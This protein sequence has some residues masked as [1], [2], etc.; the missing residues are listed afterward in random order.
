MGR[1]IVLLLLAACAAPAPVVVRTAPA[2]WPESRSREFVRLCLERGMGTEAQC[3]CMARELSD[4]VGEPAR[5]ELH[6]RID[7][8]WEV[9]DM[10]E[11]SIGGGEI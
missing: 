8:A 9:C 4:I 7:Q 5:D 10:P 2:R 3:R 6:R 1:V 11:E